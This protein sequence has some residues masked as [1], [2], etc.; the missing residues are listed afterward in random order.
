MCS[1]DEKAEFQRAVTGATHHASDPSLRGTG[2]CTDLYLAQ[3]FQHFN[4]TLQGLITIRA[5][6]ATERFAEKN[7][8]NVDFHMKHEM[9]QN[10]CSRWLTIRLQF[11]GAFSLF[12]TAL[13]ITIFPNSMDAGLTGMVINYAIQATDTME[14]F[15][16]NFTEL[17]L[18]MNALERIKYYTTVRKTPSWPISWA[19]SSLF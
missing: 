7:L 6:R 17:E 12:L 11:L 14:N 9:G 3:I 5:F 18:K 10:V 13:G 15:I 19:N 8:H 16:Q 4:E 2:C 1:G